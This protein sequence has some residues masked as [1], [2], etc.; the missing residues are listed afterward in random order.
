MRKEK[1]RGVLRMTVAIKQLSLPH[2]YLNKDF[3]SQQAK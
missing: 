2:S 3:P 1:S